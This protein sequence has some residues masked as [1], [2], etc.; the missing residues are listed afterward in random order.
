MYRNNRHKHQS[1]IHNIDLHVR[2][3]ISRA[4]RHTGTGTE[5]QIYDQEISGI[6][7]LT[8]EHKLEKVI[9]HNHR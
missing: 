9:T 5:L 6:H 2:L 4:Y 7:T 1:S 3:Q 8:S